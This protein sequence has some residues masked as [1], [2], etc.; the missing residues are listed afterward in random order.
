MGD[1]SGRLV[2]IWGPLILMGVLVL[3]FRIAGDDAGV[4]AT[5]EVPGSES[6][7]PS[8]PAVSGSAAGP[9]GVQESRH[10]FSSGQ[11]PRYAYPFPPGPGPHPAARGPVPRYPAWAGPAYPPPYP[12]PGDHSAR[13]WGTEPSEWGP[14]IGEYGPDA[15]VDP[16]WWVEPEAS[17][18]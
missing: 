1:D 6:G 2:W 7:V 16:Y 13:Y 10:G 5:A 9:R 15:E 11:A 18:E 12:W 3:V 4:A 14:P 17:G 8:S